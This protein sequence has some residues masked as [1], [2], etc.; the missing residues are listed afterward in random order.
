MSVKE[1]NIKDSLEKGIDP[2]F[3]ADRIQLLKEQKAAL[4]NDL[5]SAEREKPAHLNVNET[6]EQIMRLTGNLPEIIATASPKRVKA[7]MPHVVDRIEVDDKKRVATCY[8][9]KI[10]IPDR[11]NHGFTGNRMPEVG[12]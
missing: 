8:L 2:E 7:A 4:E 1:E 5:M 10:P 12:L 3:V 11:S 6:V 9:Y